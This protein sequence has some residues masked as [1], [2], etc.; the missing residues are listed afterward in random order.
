MNAMGLPSINNIKGFMEASEGISWMTKL[1]GKTSWKQE[2][3]FS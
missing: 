2:G 1:A 3:A